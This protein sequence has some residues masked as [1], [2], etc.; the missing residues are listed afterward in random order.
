[1]LEV[2]F[3]TILGLLSLCSLIQMEHLLDIRSYKGR[4]ENK[5]DDLLANYD[6][7]CVPDNERIARAHARGQAIEIM[8]WMSTKFLL[9]GNEW[10]VLAERW[11]LYHMMSVVRFQQYLE[12]LG[13]NAKNKLTNMQVARQFVWYHMKLPTS[14]VD[15]IRSTEIGSVAWPWPRKYETTC[16]TK[17]IKANWEIGQ[18]VFVYDH[19]VQLN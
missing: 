9:N 8:G 6:M 13:E 17:R 10:G 5:V 4:P 15:D 7:N 12:N 3:D 11:L 2:D 19:E 14:I 16:T 18:G 1:M